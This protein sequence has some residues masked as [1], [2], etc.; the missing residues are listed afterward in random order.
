[1]LIIICIYY[2]DVIDLTHGVFRNFDIS[3]HRIRTACLNPNMV[4][5]E[6]DEKVHPA[7]GYAVK[8]SK[9][10]TQKPILNVSEIL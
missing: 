5:Y 7:V 9:R 10:F 8:L 1:M 4:Y 6:E 2:Y 3:S